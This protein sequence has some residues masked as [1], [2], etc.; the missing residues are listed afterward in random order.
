MDWFDDYLNALTDPGRTVNYPPDTNTWRP[1]LPNQQQK[2]MIGD[3]MA[4]DVQQ[5]RIIQEAREQLERHGASRDA[6]LGI[7]ADPGSPAVQLV[8]PP[9]PAGI[10]LTAPT[11][12]GSGLTLTDEFFSPI[13]NASMNNPY[14]LTSPGNW[15]DSTGIGRVYYSG[16]EWLFTVYSLLSLQPF[17]SVV[18][19]NTASPASLPTSGWVNEPTGLVVTGTLVISTTP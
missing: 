14:T 12:Y 10:S 16:G 15:I 19:R 3:S 6:A 17:S 1:T 5:M 4:F 18:A 7:G 8:T 11:I 13:T 2:R 9:V